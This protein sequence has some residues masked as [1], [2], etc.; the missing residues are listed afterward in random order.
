MTVLGTGVGLASGGESGFYIVQV[1]VYTDP[2]A[3]D[4]F[5]NHLGDHHKV[6]KVTYSN[7]HATAKARVTIT[8]NWFGNDPD[9]DTVWDVP[10]PESGNQRIATRKVV[11]EPGEFSI[12]KSHV[13]IE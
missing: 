3:K 12:S 8:Q 2:D 6:I 5:G 7:G 10:C 1:L 11:L 9:T 4:E 13:A